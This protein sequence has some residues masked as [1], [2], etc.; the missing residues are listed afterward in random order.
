ME[1]VRDGL[2]RSRRPLRP[3]DGFG[4]ATITNPGKAFSTLSG[5]GSVITAACVPAQRARRAGRN[6]LP[7]P[8]GWMPLLSG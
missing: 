3:L 6:N 7:N 5:L 8:G 4:N 1:S 2:A